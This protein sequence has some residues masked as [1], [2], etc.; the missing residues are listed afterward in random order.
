MPSILTP[1]PSARPQREMWT[2]KTIDYVG[3]RV[4][5]REGIVYRGIKLHQNYINGIK[6]VIIGEARLYAR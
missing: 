3:K 6:S 1:H 4:E 2:R 5:M